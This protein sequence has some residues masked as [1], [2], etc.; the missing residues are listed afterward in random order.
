[1]TRNT[2]VLLD[3]GIDLNQAESFIIPHGGFESNARRA[4][5]PVEAFKIN[6]TFDYG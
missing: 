3:V 5:L 4:N 1:V 2:P 6:A